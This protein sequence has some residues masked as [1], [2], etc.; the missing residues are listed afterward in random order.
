VEGTACFS[1]AN[2]S[3]FSFFSPVVQNISLVLQLLEP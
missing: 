1:R 2:L 3:V